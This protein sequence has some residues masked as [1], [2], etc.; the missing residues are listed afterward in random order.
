MPGQRINGYE[1]KIGVADI[2]AAAAAVVANGAKIILPK[3]KI[4]TVGWLIKIQ[5]PVGNVVCVKQP[6]DGHP[7]SK[8]TRSQEEAASVRNVKCYS[9][10]DSRSPPSHPGGCHRGNLSVPSAAFCPT[11]Q[12]RQTAKPIQRESHPSFARVERFRSECKGGCI[13]PQEVWYAGAHSGSPLPGKTTYWRINLETW[14]PVLPVTSGRDSGRPSTADCH[15]A[16]DHELPRV[17][18]QR[19]GSPSPC[20]QT[21]VRP[22]RRRSRSRPAIPISPHRLHKGPFFTLGVSHTDPTDHNE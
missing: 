5:D 16:T 9:A 18:A 3:C 14:P 11:D 15:A 6:A 19:K 20:L 12:A 10:T 7:G 22:I 2:D 4:P 8:K 13:E 21:R 1:C 17:P